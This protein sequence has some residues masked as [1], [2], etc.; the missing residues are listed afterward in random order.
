M[1]TKQLAKAIEKAGYEVL[2]NGKV[3]GKQVKY[4]KHVHDV[5]DFRAVGLSLEPG[6][7]KKFYVHRLV[8]KLHVPNPQ[9]K[10][11]V[12][13]INGDKSDNR[14]SNLYWK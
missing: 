10:R 6:V 13:F 7:P 9:K 11:W 14:A 8:A 5:W 2:K 1:T 4:L 3:K 12:G